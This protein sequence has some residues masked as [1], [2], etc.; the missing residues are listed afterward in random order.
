MVFIPPSNQMIVYYEENK[1]L[2]AVNTSVH[3][4]YVLRKSLFTLLSCFLAPHACSYCYSQI[5]HK[6]AVIHTLF[7]TATKKWPNK[8][9]YH[10]TVSLEELSLCCQALD[11]KSQCTYVEGN[12]YPVAQAIYTCKTIRMPEAT[13]RAQCTT[14]DHKHNTASDT[15]RPLSCGGIINCLLPVIFWYF[16]KSIREGV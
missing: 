7:K 12:V 13:E 14:S 5:P 2:P 1:N 15:E 6:A 11:K 8:S 9:A 16:K 3:V 4:S 10:S